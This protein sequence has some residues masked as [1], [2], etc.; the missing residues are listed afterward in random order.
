MLD[1]K[2]PLTLQYQLRTALL[3]KISSEE[4]PAG[5]LITSERDLCEEYGVSRI[6]V[7]EV[8]KELSQS[9]YL[10]R[11]QGKG[12][13]VAPPKI[14]YAMTSAFSL[15]QELKQKGVRSA[16]IM[17][18]F[19]KVKASLFYQQNLKLNENENV[20]EVI[21][22]R[23]IEDEMYAW[24]KSVVP[25]KFLI[26]ATKEDIDQNGLYPTIQ[27]CCG[28]Y[29]TTAEENIEA[30]NCPDSIASIMNI[31]KN[32]AVIRVTR[33]TSA[34]GQLLEFCE[35]YLYGQRYKCSRVIRND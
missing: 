31:E 28:I 14:E 8:L 18:G 11:K 2:L 10:V 6:T 34:Q 15:K 27:K 16:F 23:K 3:Q 29:P 5:Y 30:S 1:N 26:G 33:V 32:K 35:S 20:F 9:G 25:S 19:N 22:L 24:E 12:T 4:W 7:R 21:R 13:Y 17:L